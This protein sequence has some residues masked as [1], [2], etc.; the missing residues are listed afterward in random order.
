MNL[1]KLFVQKNELLKPLK[2][3]K[4]STLCSQYLTS[5]TKYL[6]SNSSS[7]IISRTSNSEFINNSSKTTTSYSLM[8][9]REYKTKTRLRKRCK[10]CY[11]VWR[12]GRVYVEC[13]ENPRHKSHHMK[14]ILKGYESIAHGYDVK[15][16]REAKEAEAAWKA[17]LL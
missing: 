16:E 11:F 7:Q 8:Q 2:I 15:A 14:S 5:P 1:L 10:S 4:L 12:N 9:I 17:S 3:N 6:T 13:E